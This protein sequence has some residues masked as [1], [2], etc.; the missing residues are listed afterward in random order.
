MIGHVT[1]VEFFVSLKGFL[2]VA[3][4]DVS[5]D[6][7]LPLSWLSVCLGVVLA[8]EGVIG[9]DITDK[10]SLSLVADIDTNHHCLL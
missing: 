4:K 7:L 2:E 9:R 3:L 8:E 1:F 5:R 6:Q 10:A